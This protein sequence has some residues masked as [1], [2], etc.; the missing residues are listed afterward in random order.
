MVV[1]MVV[2]EQDDRELRRAGLWR[3]QHASLEECGDWRVS[4]REPASRL[5][6]ASCQSGSIKAEK[7][8]LS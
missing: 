1:V 4:P 7:Q 6:N 3:I 5:C 2:E 8:F